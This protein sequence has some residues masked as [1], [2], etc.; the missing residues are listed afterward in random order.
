[1]KTHRCLSTPAS[2]AIALGLALLVLGCP[3][4]PPDP[5]PRGDGAPPG[6]DVSGLAEQLMAALRARVPD[7]Q[8]TRKDAG[9]L[10][11]TG[12]ND[13]QLTLS[14]DNLSLR[15]RSDPASC[16]AGVE[17]FAGTV[18]ENLKALAADTRP[19]RD[20]VRAQ[21]K[22]DGYM[23]KVLGLLASAPQDKAQDNAILSRRFLGDLWIAYVLD[24][25]SSTSLLTRA[26]LK[27]LALQEDEVPALA[28]ANLRKACP[29]APA[30]PLPD[31][32][33]VWAVETGDSYEAARLLLPELWA[34]HKARLKGDLVACA[35]IR[36]VVL[37]TDSEDRKALQAMQLLAG[38]LVAAEA[39]PLSRRLL[40]WTPEGFVE[41]IPHPVP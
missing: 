16:Q 32:P 11:V 22:D 39:Y 30:K 21:L 10:L 26:D 23:Q 20:M 18:Q 40:R 38:Q 13:I 29:D 15:C 24:R 8:V 33:G 3:A 1:M 27:K 12:A 2:P 7:V 17:Q 9:T 25:P 28:L 19:T 37:F 6:G 34:G 35:P 14:L 31:F 41:F 5:G 36:D 4:S